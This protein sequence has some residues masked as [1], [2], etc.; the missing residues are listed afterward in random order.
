VVSRY[1]K[2]APATTDI[3]TAYT[4]ATSSAL[5]YERLDEP[6]SLNLPGDPEKPCVAAYPV[7][8]RT[9]HRDGVEVLPDAK[10]V[11]RAVE[12]ALPH[13]SSQQTIRWDAP[14]SVSRLDAKVVE[15]MFTPV[16][17]WAPGVMG[18]LS[19]GG[20]PHQSGCACTARPSVDLDCG[21]RIDPP[22]AP[23]VGSG[24]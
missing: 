3:P 11:E 6:A 5:V 16:S 10:G 17:A 8:E 12:R 20:V 14:S 21:S 22:E 18:G 2:L 13:T 19:V 1:Q 4:P 24:K 23:E 9:R 15:M 7:G